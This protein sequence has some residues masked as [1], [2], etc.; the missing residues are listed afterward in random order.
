MDTSEPFLK[1]HIC[2]AGSLVKSF[3]WHQGGCRESEVN[4]GLGPD[5]QGMRCS[6]SHLCSRRRLLVAVL[7]SLA[8]GVMVLLLLLNYKCVMVLRTCSRN[9]DPY[10]P[11]I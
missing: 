9:D 2:H 4:V 6:A 11:K 8:L 1:S 5:E 3:I 10:V 7:V